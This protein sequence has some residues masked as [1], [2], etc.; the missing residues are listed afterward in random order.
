M[1]GLSVSAMLV[2][3]LIL[4]VA[5]LPVLIRSEAVEVLKEATGREARIEK[6]SLNPL[7]LTVGIKGFAIE[8]K[9]GGPFFSVDLLRVSLSPASLYQRALVLSEVT[10]DSPSLRIVREAVDRFNFSEILARQKRK[11][12][13]PKPA[14]GLF[15]VVVNR[16]RLTGGM[17]DFDDRAVGGVRK[18][19]LHDLRIDLPWLSTLPDDVD[20]EAAPRITALVNG[21]TL[22]VS[23]SLKPFH[24]DPQGAL[25]IALGGLDL[26]EL[27]AYAPQPLP[28]ELAS[29]RLTLDTDILLK[30]SAGGVPELA[31]R[32]LAR[33]DGIVLN[34]AKGK[35]LM[36][37]SM[38]E[39][40]VE[41]LEPFANIY[42][43][44]SVSTEGLEAFVS[45]DSRGEWMFAPLLSQG[46]ARPASAKAAGD[47]LA[48]AKTVKPS[49]TAK[50]GVSS[51][52]TSQGATAEK[53]MAAKKPAL[54]AFSLAE[55][56]LKG[57][58]IHFRDDLPKEGF[59]AVADQI[60]LTVKNI[61][62]RPDRTG[63]YDLSLVVDRELRLASQ[64]SF[65]LAEPAA[66]AS[67]QM[68]GLK[69][70]KVWPYL[71]AYLT[72]PVEGI[73]DLSGEAAYSQK[74]GVAARK[75]KLNLRDLA[76]RYGNG[77]G[78]SLGRLEV[79]GASF[80]QK[81]NR[82]EIDEIR[83]AGGDASLSREADGQLSV[84][85]LLVQKGPA[86]AAGSSVAGVA[87]PAVAP[88]RPVREGMAKE[89][90]GPALHPVHPLPARKTKTAESAAAPP[91]Y[92]IGKIGI[93]RF[94]LAVTDRMRPQTPR[95]TLRN[96][97]ASL[98][99][100]SGPAPK[101]ARLRLA[102]TF[103]RE[104]P[105]EATGNLTP[106]PLAY[107]GTL[108]I[109]RLPIRDFEAYF[110]DTLNFLIL[111]GLLDLGL[112]LDIALRDGVP[113]GSVRGT[114]GLSS[115]HA[116]DHVEQEDLLKWQRLQIEGI[117]ADLRP[118]RL[119][120]G[121]IA[122]T[123][124]FARIIIR[125]DTTLNLQN[126]VRKDKAVGDAEREDKG[127]SPANQ[128]N[129]TKG[130]AAA[131]A[132]PE[133]K[134][135]AGASAE[136]KEP[137]QVRIDTVTLVDGTVDFTDKH[138]SNDF[139]TTF[140]K[141]GGRISGLTSEASRTAD[142]DLRGT[143]ENRSPM[144]IAG[145]INPLREDLFVDLKLTFMDID[146]SPMSPYSETY[147]GYI[148]KQGKLFLDLS[149]HIEN[150][151]L[152]SENKVRIDQFAFGDAVKSDKAT[153]L[154]VKL[155]IALLKDRN[156]E[157]NLDVPVM[158][159]IDDPR[160]NIWRIVFQVIKN[161]LV[162][163]VTAP[164]SLLSSLF[165]GGSDLSVVG[166]QPGMSALAPAEEQKLVSLAKGLADR[167]ALKMSLT[168]Y[169][170]PEKDAEGYRNELLERK[171][172]R[173]KELSLAR[174]RQAERA[175]GPTAVTLSPEERS[176]YLK[177]LYGREQFPKPLDAAGRELALPDA[178][179]VKLL[180]AH[181]RVER[182]ELEELARERVEA[183]RDFLIQKGG[184]AAERI[185][186][187]NDE[188]FKPPAK[189]ETPRSRAELNAIQ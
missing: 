68:A 163:A 151:E 104:T 132:V 144:Q 113:Q 180:L 27:A 143:L 97:E 127:A 181:T 2:L 36:K 48:P 122:L 119:A 10:I 4:S 167:P 19:T 134:P 82:L 76:A 169:A 114:A 66:S 137:T 176:R 24:R 64:G 86:Q 67:L 3:L 80:S 54:P 28:A 117:D 30:L 166:F 51:G 188:L 32:G 107:Q 158:G 168:A 22:A 141:L 34:L 106:A 189:G 187:Q 18:H 55:L 178:E 110:P 153:S 147:L 14:A 142:V 74:E 77:E 20:R 156:G 102:T 159:R 96:T 69:L 124:P 49:D 89:G 56:S 47:K 95:F 182:P 41:R 120:I 16:L 128:A 177:A 131:K 73:V 72:A 140:Y 186:P 5:L 155:G 146:L 84:M 17:F 35:P 9:G 130:E 26:P 105:I 129:G 149:Y 15:P 139:R 125:E 38:L 50:A 185:F 103:G 52:E 93:E 123:E 13:T 59:E 92:R 111:G 58:R 81:A 40:R 21:A 8:E 161:L 79:S 23:G 60:T 116:V 165:G 100:F 7:T 154:P 44:A 37:L 94:N 78:F 148:L 152:A 63:Q 91:A 133:V 184:V 101:P 83:L 12:E 164:F 121:Q 136:R 53:A 150:G 174:E 6:I 99:D 171:L 65:N 170:D 173:E 88:I 61:A 25:H 183:V 179:M 108:R 138:L 126:L 172:R 46:G 57:G 98:A 45:R 115:F 29:G 87:E 162:K 145:R 71:A 39:A 1:I 160:F 70:Q 11:E 118:L 175:G 135:S 42:D 62:T 31:V 85:S 90:S 109:G 75:G 157:I 33:L 43:L 112:S